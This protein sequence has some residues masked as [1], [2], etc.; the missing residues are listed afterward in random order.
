MIRLEKNQELCALV[1]R[2]RATWAALDGASDADAAPLADKLKHLESQI[3]ALPVRTAEELAAK[4]QIVSA[5][6]EN[7]D[8][9]ARLMAEIRKLAERV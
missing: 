7:L 4:I 5:D 8:S 1:R 3:V 6:G 9:Q 2:W